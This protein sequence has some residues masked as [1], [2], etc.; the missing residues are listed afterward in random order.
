VLKRADDTLLEVTGSPDVA[1]TLKNG[2]EVRFES[3][4]RIIHTMNALI[5][6][7]DNRP[8]TRI[9]YIKIHKAEVEQLSDIKVGVGITILVMAVLAS[10]AAVVRLSHGVGPK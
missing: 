2:K 7:G 5:L 6:S 1:V 9:P 3:P 8:L 10:G 4:V